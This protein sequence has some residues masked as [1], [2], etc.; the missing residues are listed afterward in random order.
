MRDAYSY[1]RDDN[2]SSS[3]DEQ[4][5]LGGNNYNDDYEYNNELDEGD[6]EDDGDCEDDNGVRSK[7]DPLA[8]QV[9]KMYSKAKDSLDGQRMEN[10]TWRMMSL[11]LHK[12]DANAQNTSNQPSRHGTQLG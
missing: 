3:E 7:E 1:I 11:S 6:E 12:K 9:W 2:N 5:V 8:S 10:M 4:D